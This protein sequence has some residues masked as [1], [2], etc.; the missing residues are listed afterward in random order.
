MKS[1]VRRRLLSIFNFQFSI[2]LLA[3]C[4][5]TPPPPPLPPLPVVVA[6]PP[7]ELLPATLEEATPLRTS[8]PAKYERALQSLASSPDPLT[9][10]RA[11][12]ILGL[13]QLDAKRYDDAFATLTKAADANPLIAPFLRLR[14]A[15]IETQR[16]NFANAASIAAQIV[17]TSS[18][19]SAATIAR[20]RL[21]ALYAQA[22][23]TTS[24]DAAFSQ[25][26][27]TALDELTESEFVAAAK[28]L[29]QSVRPDLASAIRM[30]LLTEFPQGR[31]TEDT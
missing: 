16:N 19:S 1:R 7:A 13:F 17:A 5:H 12:A 24:A 28:S 27:T 11:L 31:F 29:D 20:L 26:M 22:G 23:D 9:S 18:D 25:A 2:L 21:P 15:D 14:L 6:K 4:A 3:A 30:R 8:D 10:R